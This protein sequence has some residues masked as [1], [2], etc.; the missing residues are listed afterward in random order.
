MS[1]SFGGFKGLRFMIFCGPK[2]EAC[3]VAVGVLGFVAW[4]IWGVSGWRG[5][6]VFE[7]APDL[8]PYPDPRAPNPKLRLFEASK[9][10]N[11]SQTEPQ[12]LDF[13][14]LGEGGV[15]VSRC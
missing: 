3:G 5:F 15:L 12:A 7:L 11:P 2:F 6:V 8:E 9:L 4:G 14:A 1:G 13:R 10:R